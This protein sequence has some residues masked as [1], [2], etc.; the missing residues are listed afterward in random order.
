MNGEKGKFFGEFGKEKSVL[1]MSKMKNG[2]GKSLKNLPFAPKCSEKI[3]WQ[4]IFVTDFFGH[5]VLDNDNK[6]ITKCTFWVFV[7]IKYIL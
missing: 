2:Q 3:V 6:M 1:D 5:P 7:L 4:K